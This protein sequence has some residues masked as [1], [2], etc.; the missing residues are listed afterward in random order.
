[1]DD[2]QLITEKIKTILKDGDGALYNA[3]KDII[4]ESSLR[5]E[6]I[7]LWKGKHLPESTFEK[8]N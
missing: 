4:T 5:K 6:I 7:Q 2:Y 1:M 3:E 8:T